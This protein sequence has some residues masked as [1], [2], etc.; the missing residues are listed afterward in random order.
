MADRAARERVRNPPPRPVGL[1]LLTAVI[2]VALVGRDVFTFSV[3]SNEAIQTWS[4]IFV[5]ITIQ[6]LPF[7]GLGVIVSGAIAAFVSDRVIQRTLPRRPSVAVPV[8]G[9]LGAALPGCECGSVPLA[10]R[11]MARGVAPSAALTFMLSSPAINPVVLV[12]TAVAF[13][14]QPVVVVARFAA[15]L[16]AAVVIGLLWARW[17]RAEWLQVPRRVHAHGDSRLQTFRLT[18][19][20]DFLQSAGFL[21]VGGF[22]AATLNV[23]VDPSWSLTVAGVP[24]VSV[25]VLAVLAVLLAVCSEADAFVAAS[26]TGFSLTAKL[27]FMVVG[28][29]V[30]IKLIVMQAGT[31]GRRFAL[32]FASLTFVVAVAI[33][34]LVGGL[35][36]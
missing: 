34:L 36:L 33:V 25:L 31:F 7:L 15:S 11:L 14:Q 18:V 20:Y 5:A 28:P 3:G 30:D 35:I 29:A 32:R 21:V 4:T 6:A 26:L 27:A 16:C 1:I 13:P 10:G 9:V 19:Q 23:A 2:G 24:V 12:A 22:F 8:A 17:G